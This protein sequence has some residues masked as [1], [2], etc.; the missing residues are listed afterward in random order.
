MEKIIIYSVGSDILIIGNANVVDL[1]CEYYGLLT[2]IPYPKKN[3]SYG[4]YDAENSICAMVI[5]H[6][7]YHFCK[8]YSSYRI[9]KKRFKK[10]STDNFRLA[11]DCIDRL[12]K[13]AI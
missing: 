9:A 6:N 12:S 4:I 7:Q 13:T 10:L 1:L 5:N 8:R 3:F 2:N 11:L